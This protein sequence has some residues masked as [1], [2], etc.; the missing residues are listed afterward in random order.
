MA[1][2]ERKLTMLAE[3]GTVVG[4][5]EMIERVEAQLG[6]DPLVVVTKQRKGWNMSIWTDDD[7]TT[8]KN[9]GLPGWTW[10]VAAF[11]IVVALGG[12]YLVLD[13]GGGGDAVTPAPTTTAPVSQSTAPDTAPTTTV[14][15]T[16]TTSA[17]ERLAARMLVVEAMIEARNSGDYE[18][19]RSFFPED[20]PEIFGGTIEDESE[21]EWQR[22]HM[23]AND[24]WTIT[25]ECNDVGSRVLCPMTLVN[26]FYGPAGIFYTVPG[27]AFD[28]TVEDELVGIGSG[29]WDIAGDPEEY[30]GAFDSW[31]AEAYPE[32]HA[33]FGP[34]VEGEGALPN[35][36]DM[37]IAVQYVD[38]F[39]AQSD[40]Y[41]LSD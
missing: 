23:A 25:G 21:L 29:F 5:E 36:E 12:L 41:P 24:V 2:F 1:D 16:P 20:R 10:A 27:M 22:S 15:V 19:W 30:A 37:P 39:I 3:R 33:G 17:G 14:E 11:L 40:V 28:F 18:A 38:E 6:S 7:R 31:L 9:T 32:I 34:R 35:P 26:G 13:N 8:R 4:P